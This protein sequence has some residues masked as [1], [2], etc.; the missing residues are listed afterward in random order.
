MTKEKDESDKKT[1]KETIEEP[2]KNTTEEKPAA[3]KLEHTKEIFQII[4]K[5][6]GLIS[7]V[8]ITLIIV[9]F[10]GYLTGVSHFSKDQQLDALSNQIT[11]GKINQMESAVVTPQ[12]H[13]IAAKELQPLKK[14]LAKDKTT[15]GQIKTIIGHESSYSNFQIIQVGT[16]FGIYPKY[17]VALEKRNIVVETNAYKPSFKVNG[18]TSPAKRDS[19]EYYLVKSFPGSYTV[20]VK[21]KSGS[22]QKTKNVVVPVSGN[23]DE[24]DIN[25][26]MRR[27]PAI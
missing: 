19:N 18:K 27:S 13:S 2:A 25:I 11:S 20:D 10:I 3:N 6:R 14:L 9:L 15:S 17:K 7:F 23:C 22:Y 4:I 8:A 1:D 5:K 12:K 21:N 24:T 16:Y 26:T